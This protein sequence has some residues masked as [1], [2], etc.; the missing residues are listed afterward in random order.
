MSS[1][2]SFFLVQSKEKLRVAVGRDS[3]L[4][5]PS[6]CHA[7]LEGLEHAAPGSGIELGLCTTPATFHCCLA[8]PLGISTS[9]SIMVTAS[10]LPPDRNG[11]KLF[12]PQGGLSEHDVSELIQIA[13]TLYISQNGGGYRGDGDSKKK[14]KEQFNFL[15]DVYGS[16][17]AHLIR[18]RARQT[19]KD[20][21]LPLQGIHVVVN[22][23]HGAGGFF[24]DVLK[25]C[26]AETRGSLHLEPDG[27]FPA[28]APNPEDPQ[29]MK[30]TVNAVLS[31]KAD[32][33]VIFDPDC[34]RLGL[35]KG[36]GTELNRNRLIAMASAVVLRSHP[37]TT[38]VTDSV[39][40]EGLARFIIRHGGS[41]LRFKK[42]Y[43]NVI[44]EAISM[45]E[46]GLDCQ[47]AMEC[48]GHAA[49]KV[50]R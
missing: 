20:P 27:N 18:E 50:R 4:T 3:R 36:D 46:R 31:S 21:L 48:S 1:L 8:P 24:V 37:G 42:G 29:A 45:N 44:D 16:H 41:H 49:F 7:I 26:G 10:H 2:S 9:G 12:R 40:S 22:P 38:I 32:L 35:V 15:R 17:L 43:R 5:G 33:G 47:L 13:A 23:G 30:A 28:H 14:W 34:D 6:L 19:A 11:M 25:D 39:T